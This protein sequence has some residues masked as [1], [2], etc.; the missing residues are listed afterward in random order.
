[1]LLQVD[2]A[3]FGALGAQ[4]VLTV[5]Q[6]TVEARQLVADQVD[7]LAASGLK[8]SLDVSF[9]RV[10][11]A[12]AQLLLVQA[13]NDVQASFAALT[14]AMGFDAAGN[15]RS[16]GRT[17]P[18]RRRPRTA[19]RSWRRRSGT[20]PTSPRDAWRGTGGARFAAAERALWYPSSRPSAPPA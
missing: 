5:A 17:A 2:R 13:Q 7:A 19:P 1:M 20:G 16:A 3:Y 10:N 9:A 4:A 8:S 18:G 11:L 12:Q 14:A 15:L 6:Q